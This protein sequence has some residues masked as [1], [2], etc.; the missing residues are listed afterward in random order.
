M[1][2]YELTR[3]EFDAYIKKHHEHLFD[4]VLY[5]DSILECYKVLCAL[6]EIMEEEVCEG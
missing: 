6:K 2:V 1:K 5:A 3:E 4:E